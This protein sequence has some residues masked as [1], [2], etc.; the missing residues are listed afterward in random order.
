MNW[1]RRALLGGLG[2]LLPIFL[3]FAYVEGQLVVEFVQQII[4]AWD[5]SG[6]Q[7]A[8]VVANLSGLIAQV[9]GLFLLGAVWASVQTTE[10]DTAR[11][12]VQLGLVAPAVL[13]T[14]INANNASAAGSARTGLTLWEPPAAIVRPVETVSYRDPR[15]WVLASASGF[16]LPVSGDRVFQ[17]SPGI[18]Q[19]FVKGLQGQKC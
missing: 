15:G 17:Q 13:T 8:L 5:Q 2:A 10:T 12:I 18:F 14:L 6:V 16:A 19:C 9:V 3:T 11:R 1:F 4:A 7:I